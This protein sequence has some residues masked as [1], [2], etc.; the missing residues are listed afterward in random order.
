MKRTLSLLAWAL[1]ACSLSF[2]VGCNGGSKPIVLALN[3]TGTTAID[4]GQSLNITVSG[5]GGKGVMWSL[6]SVG[7]LTNM[8]TT[9]VT[10]NAPT[11]VTAPATDHLTATSLDD[12]TKT[13]VLAITVNPSPSITTTTLPAGTEGTAYNQTVAASGGAGML[14]FSVSVGTLPAGLTMSA[15]GV[16]TGT[17]TGP[18]TPSSFTIKVTDSSTA[19]TGT[20]MG[21]QSATKALSILINLPT[22]PSITTTSLPDGTQGAAYNQTVAATAGLTPYTFTIVVPG[23]GTLPAGLTLSNAGVISGTPTGLGTSTFTVKVTDSSNPTQSATQNL[24]IK[25]DPAP[26]VI[27]TTSLPNGFVSQTGYS[28][29]LASTGGAP[30]VNWSIT[31]GA[32]PPGLTLAVGSSG[33]ITGTP[34]T[35][36][37]F[38]V[39]VTA[40]DSSTPALTNSKPLSIT[41]IPQLK[42]TTGSPL[43]NGITNTAYS[44]TLASTGGSGAVTW[45]LS[46]GTTLP[47]N[48]SLNASTGAITGT[49]TTAGTSSFT[50]QA[51]D[52]GTPQQK[53]TMA[54]TITIIQQLVITTPAALP[55]GT[56]NQGASFGQ[57]YIVQLASSGGTGAVSWALASGST[58]PAALTLSATGRLCCLPT[59]AGTFH[60]SI[61]A[62]DSGPPQQTAT[63]AFTLTITPMLAITTTQA[64]IPS[65]TVGTAYSTTIM[66]NNG[67]IAPYR[68]S[69]A[70]LSGSSLPPGLSIA[71]GTGV[72][73]GTP[74]TAGTFN[75]S[76]EVNDSQQP[77]PGESNIAVFTI[78][79]ATAP[80][81]V[82]TTS[83]PNAIVGQ[84]YNQTLASAGGNP[85]VAWSISAGSLPSWATLTAGAITGTPPAG[86]TGTTTFTVKA[87]DSSTP[88]AQTATKQLSITVV[89]ALSITTATLPNG[90][91]GAAYST[92]VAATGGTTPYVWSWA[93]QTGTGSSL[94][95][96]LSIASGTGVISG[97]PGGSG[98]TFS[99]TVTV[100]DS[101]TNP[102]QTASA[103]FTITITV[104]TLM[105]TTT[106]S[107]LPTGTVNTA[108]PNTP[109]NASGGISPYTW[110][111]TGGALPTG[112]MMST[113]GVISG[114]P[115]VSGTFNF[116]VTVT[117][118]AT[119][120][121]TA[122]LSITV[123][124]A[125][126]CT[127]TGGS[128][129]LLNGGYAFL[130]KGFDSSS[131][132]ALVGGVLTFNGSGTISAGAID[133]NVNPTPQSLTVTSGTY[134]VGS[135]H[136][137]CMTIITSGGTQ[138]Y[139][140][141]VA[142]I[143]GTP[144]VA[145]T[146]HVINF[147]AAGP[148]TTGTMFKQS[149]GTF[150]V[151]SVS[152]TFAFGGSSIQNTAAGGGRFGIAGL[153]T[154]NGSGGITSGTEDIN[155]N[156][157][158]DGDT[159]GTVTSFPAT[160]PITFSPAPAST[161]S[162]SS[163]GR[164]NLTIAIAGAAITSHAFLYGVSSSHAF[165]MTSDAQTGTQI[166]GGEALLQSGTPFATNPL[167][168]TFTGYDSGT[169]KG[170]AG[171]DRADLYFVGPQT[172]GSSTLNLTQY[173]NDGGTFTS[174]AQA[175]SYSVSSTGRMLVTG[176]GGHEPV[177]Y[178]VSA[179]QAF[180]VAGNGSVD[181]GFI[182]SQTGT[183]ASGAFAFGVIDPEDVN[184]SPNSGV[185]TLS[186]GSITGTSDNNSSGGGGPQ[187]NQAISTTY[188]VDA[189]GLGHIPSGCAITSTSTTCQLIFVVVSPTRAFL[190]ELQHSGGTAQTSPAINPVDQ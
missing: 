135:D 37:T 100:A 22:P 104:A 153:L 6:A 67:G 87:T 144:A 83:L 39:T 189:N 129:S 141:S 101:A 110:A 124:P 157:F 130:L 55:T 173:R 176:V 27:T 3:F 8:T 137:G 175:G 82:A 31:A 56:V 18:N 77:P 47:P 126:A 21:S 64:Q 140:F 117:D 150:S 142:N 10:Y 112:M 5:A 7:T 162:I 92:T 2:I 16:I 66:S 30:P 151:A 28:A 170:G 69:W 120:T 91:V 159:T 72:I 161:Y 119:H 149:G 51:A 81:S 158:L 85:P 133:M 74:T 49:P 169:G 59:T 15:A 89:S 138:H 9:S 127:T 33:Q 174:G 68:W 184:A 145:S 108:Y 88:T 23:T 121:A 96:G 20:N 122:T 52:S 62:T 19:N 172:S 109:L 156:G 36:G 65:G 25:V 80:L 12:S 42:I 187:P 14:T 1:C 168:G 48:L 98:G 123:N 4:N 171:T 71:S 190:T 107:N 131:E 57:L 11:S 166:V 105:V 95:P 113:A 164:G 163:N 75:V 53:V 106:S 38:S 167:S 40:T 116:T 111:V 178:L 155:L 34:T 84:A 102:Q 93:P 43:P 24:S 132:P 29:T 143:S 45:T 35:A 86:A 147:D 179:S 61:T 32:L 148:F 79:I 63:V 76:V 50:V 99:V 177:L 185:V 60:F 26:V 41:I 188:S 118:S 146:A 160:S 46:G 58:L 13:I 182:Q 70:A 115:T 165:F 134:G 139:A 103:N 125:G 17:P 94:P 154:F 114:T 136:R 54:L 97:T 78:S 152:G 128:E 73:S 90:T 180:L 186:S 181:T 183:T 44:V